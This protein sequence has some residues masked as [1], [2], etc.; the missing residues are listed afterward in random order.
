MVK[1]N[2]ASWGI[3]GVWVGGRQNRMIAVGLRCRHEATLSGGI[4]RGPGPDHTDC[5]GATGRDG[6]D[7]VRRSASDVE[8]NGSSSN[9]GGVPL[10]SK[11]WGQL[12]TFWGSGSHGCIV[13]FAATQPAIFGGVPLAVPGR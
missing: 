6:T 3:G 8:E 7:V 13:E 5:Q 11:L 9:L 10:F 4:L 12:S 2:G 1:Y